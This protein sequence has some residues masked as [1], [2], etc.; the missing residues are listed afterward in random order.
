M[1]DPTIN[2][3]AVQG[4]DATQIDLTMA[5]G[6]AAA[7]AVGPTAES[8]GVSPE[9]FAKFN[10][11]DGYNWQAHAKELEFAAAQKVTAREPT[12]DP[13]TPGAPA[14]EA[15]AKEVTDSAGLDWN[16]L[17]LKIMNDGDISAD[18][19]TKLAG[20][21]VPKEI[22]SEYVG[23]VKDSADNHVD[24]VLSAFGGEEQFNAIRTA[25]QEAFTESELQDI[26][27]RMA[28]KAGWSDA[29]KEVMNKVGAGEPIN[30]SQTAPN[31]ASTTGFK[32]QAEMVAAMRKP[33]Y[34]RDP[35]YR[36]EIEA[37]VAAS[38]WDQ[39]PRQHVG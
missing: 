33:E 24:K 1:A 34:R 23:L 9:Q 13:V 7:P 31:A 5:D 25:A 21:G 11:A 17:S 32:S 3:A 4:S 20:V 8:M 2:V 36:A 6:A 26:E 15:R 29:V 28:Q 35:A 22:V 14:D 16:D 18:D 39:N 37:K 12:K 19:Y 38:K 30:A 10:S 27:T